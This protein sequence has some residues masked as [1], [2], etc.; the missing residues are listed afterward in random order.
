MATD[1]HDAIVHPLRDF[2]DDLNR[3]VSLRCSPQASSY[4]LEQAFTEWALEELADH[5]ESDNADI[6]GEAPFV[7]ES[8]GQWPAAKLNAWAL[9]GDG[10][11]LDLY[12]SY[13][14]RSGSV[15]RLSLPDTRRLYRLVL[16]LLRRALDGFHEKQLDTNSVIYGVCKAIFESRD[17]LTT[18]RLILLTNQIANA[19]DIEQERIESLE[20]RYVLWDLQKFSQLQIGH[21]EVVTIDF[22]SDFGRAVPCLK[23]PGDSSEFTTYLFFIPGRLLAQVYGEH[24]QRLLER[25]VRAFLQ[26]KNKVNS[27]IQKTIRETPKRFLSYNNG[28]CCTASQVNIESSEDGALGLVWAKDF[29]IVNGGQTTA[30]IYRA[31]KKE[32]LDID[33]IAVQ[34]KLT[35]VEQQQQVDELVPLIARFANSQNKVS[36]AD[37][38]A[39]GAFH[40]QLEKLSR[41]VWA[42]ATDGLAK[43]THWYYER[44]RGS[45]SDD[46][47]RQEPSRRREWEQQNPARKKFTKTDL[48]KY[49]NAWLGLPHYVCRGA[50]KNFVKFAERID[51]ASIQIDQAFFQH[52]VA[53]AIL[54]RTAE[55]L[56]DAL[57]LEGYRSHTVA[58]AISW[59]AEKSSRRI[60]LDRIWKDQR[61]SATI[62]EC[63]KIAL[64]EARAFLEEQGGDK[65]EASK[66][67]ELWLKFSKTTFALPEGWKNELAAREFN[68]VASIEDLLEHK[69]ETVRLKF[70][71]DIRTFDVLEACTGKRWL[72]NRGAQTVQSIA[73]MPWSKLVTEVKKSP[74]R[75]S[76]IE[77]LE[78]VKDD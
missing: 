7:A 51:D 16:G 36:T 38:A 62:C 42:P 32:C 3:D 29:Q 24:G 54:W 56:F 41:T 8:R 45:Y 14:Q 13:F 64:R 2:L 65:G 9:S 69:W 26:T 77:L 55:R 44:A 71:A 73:T 47:A 31:W 25:N 66:K 22:K 18:V 46:K 50:E 12:V 39:N 63:L 48:A 28:L 70:L 30:S 11:T 27:S 49:E 5:N 40:Q 15:D 76:L 17:S 20:I 21:R 68:S 74:S 52:V 61:P 59:L 57:G 6:I 60:D 10:A 33:E 67:E 78:A 4:E 43:G 75:R 1:L 72:R 34:V 35:V 58:Y 23:Q 37:L 53:R 19:E